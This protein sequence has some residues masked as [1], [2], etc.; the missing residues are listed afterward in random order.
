MSLALFL[1]AAVGGAALAAGG[2]L[3]A[4][5]VFGLLTLLALGAALALR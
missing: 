3:A 4:A 5:T 2:Y 1:G